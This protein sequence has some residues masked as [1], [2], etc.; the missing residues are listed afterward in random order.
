M[1]RTTLQSAQENS[2]LAHYVDPLSPHGCTWPTKCLEIP[3]EAWPMLVKSNL[4]ISLWNHRHMDA[5][6]NKDALCRWFP[7]TERSRAVG[8]AMAGFH[9]G[10]VAGLM[11]TPTL[12]GSRFGVKTPFAAFA[13]AGFVWLSLWLTFITKNPESQCR[14]STGEYLHIKEANVEES[15]VVESKKLAMKS[16]SQG[17]TP[18]FGMLLSKL[19]TWAIIIANFTNNWVRTLHLKLISVNI[20]SCTF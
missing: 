10:S 4:F 9:L 12:L 15:S 20:I 14:I 19:P 7:R 1:D 8:M 5:C 13:S 17:G 18:P 6:L 3:S 11:F 16:N 2:S